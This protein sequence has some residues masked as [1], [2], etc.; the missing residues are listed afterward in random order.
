MLYPV[1]YFLKYFDKYYTTYKTIL[2]LK[3]NHGFVFSLFAF[4]IF[5][6]FFLFFFIFIYFSTEK[7]LRPFL[8]LNGY[9]EAFSIAYSQNIQTFERNLPMTFHQKKFQVHQRDK[10]QNKFIGWTFYGNW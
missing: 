8:I 1:S 5:A 9:S 6:I 10:Y 7:M 2:F 4:F 3:F